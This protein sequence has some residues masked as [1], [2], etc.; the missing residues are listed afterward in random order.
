[1]KISMIAA[2]GR[3]REIGLKNELLWHISEDLKRFKRITSGHTVI[4]GRLT[5][6]SIGRK[7]L[8]NRRNI[9][10]SKS[11]NDEGAGVEFARSVSE[12]IAKVK[13]EDEVFIIGGAMIYEQFMPYADKLYLTEVHENYQA[14]SFFPNYDP[15]EWEVVE[16]T[17]INDDQ[18]ASV[19]YS[20]VTLERIK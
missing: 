10:L 6:E 15:E 11:G 19:K 18:Q 13:D 16:M 9:V 12:A 20:F 17:D 8:P 1:M 5:F 4:M 7:P 2:Y 3:N 14:D